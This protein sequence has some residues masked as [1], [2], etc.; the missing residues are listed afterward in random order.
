MWEKIL[1]IFLTLF[2]IILY[3]LTV[4]LERIKDDPILKESLN[5]QYTDF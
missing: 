1:I 4:H 5:I 3:A 2:V